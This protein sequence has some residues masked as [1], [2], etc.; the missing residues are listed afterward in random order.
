M[1]YLD[2]RRNLKLG[3]SKQDSKSAKTI[4]DELDVYYADGLARAPE[5]C[6]E[7]GA[8]LAESM[9]IN[10]RT[11]VCHI[12]AKSK[13]SGCP[14]VQ[15]HPLNMWHGCEKCHTR[16]DKASEEEIANMKIFK[17]L[18]ARVAKFFHLIVSQEQRRV[19]EILQP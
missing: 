3:K 8:K 7:C 18:R 2:Y 4:K 5:K 1:S 14:S 12:V 10:S 11:V 19:P 9:V 13:E 15:A 17:K 16:Y 6:E